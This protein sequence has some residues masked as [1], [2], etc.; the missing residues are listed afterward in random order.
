MEIL[1]HDTSKKSF[2]INQGMRTW[3]E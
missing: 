1:K 3:N 2:I